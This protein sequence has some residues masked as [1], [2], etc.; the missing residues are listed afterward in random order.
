MKQ[1]STLKP[2]FHPPGQETR[3]V[4]FE[5]CYWRVA[6]VEEIERLRNMRADHPEVVAG[7][8]R[9]FQFIESFNDRLQISDRWIL[10]INGEWFIYDGL[11]P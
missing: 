2:D 6:T 10:P 1:P 8:L 9:S 5:G 3:R 11:A 7:I 4:V